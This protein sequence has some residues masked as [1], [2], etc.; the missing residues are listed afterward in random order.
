MCRK[1]RSFHI[2]VT[3][4]VVRVESCSVWISLFRDCLMSEESGHGKVQ[5]CV[6]VIQV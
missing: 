4:S 3:K 6:C 5:G 2:C 1:S